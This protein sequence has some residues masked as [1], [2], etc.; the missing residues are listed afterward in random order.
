MNSPIKDL[1]S[2]DLPSLDKPSRLQTTRQQP[3]IVRRK[4]TGSKGCNTVFWFCFA[5]VVLAFVT[6]LL[7]PRTAQ[8]PIASG[9]PIPTTSPITELAEDEARQIRI[10]DGSSIAD[11]SL[12]TELLLDSTRKCELLNPSPQHPYTVPVTVTCPPKAGPR[13]KLY[14][15]AI[16]PACGGAE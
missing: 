15:G 14:N 11:E 4:K 1:D 8:L 13:A 5:G 6:M 12:Y 10:A 3:G 7:F 9:S 2:V 16:H